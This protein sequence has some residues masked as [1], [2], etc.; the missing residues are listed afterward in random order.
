MN[1]EK[2]VIFDYSGTLSLDAVLF[3][4]PECLAQQLEESGLSEL[5]VTSLDFFWQEIVNA[6]WTEGSTTEIGY[7]GV[8][9][10]RLRELGLPHDARA[11]SSGISAAAT[12]FVHSYLSHST[13]DRRWQPLLTKLVR[14]PATCVV[15]ATDHYAE[16]TGCI[17]QFLEDLA[18]PARPAGE[19]FEHPDYDAAIVANSADL[20]YPKA[21]RRFWDIVRDRL[22]L[23]TVRQ[24]LCVDDFGYHESERDDYGTLRKVEARQDTT[25][26]LLEEVFAGKITIIPFLIVQDGSGTSPASMDT[27]AYHDLID[28]TTGRIDTWVTEPA[29]S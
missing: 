8:I 29:E 14:H 17:V 5:G 21:D 4:R 13:V 24:V 26:R 18:I 7:T 10:K 3:A 22:G 28:T 2:L 11:G 6:T 15:V 12:R 23:A 19:M 25:T 20:G 27:T 16:A 9:A 1:P